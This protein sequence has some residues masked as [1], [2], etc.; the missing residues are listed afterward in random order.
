M[1]IL[2]TSVWIE[3]FKGKEPY[4]KEVLG[5]IESRS[6]IALEPVFGE[7]LQGALSNRERDY[8]MSFW[9]NLSKIEISDLFIKAGNLSY[10]EKLV[11]KGVRLID[12]GIIY[13]TINYKNTLW[14]LDKKILKSLEPKYLYQFNK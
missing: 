4:F 10:E 12:A 5:L 3:F 1:V 8:I 14:T 9:M 2:D 13:S 6:V 7:L 11:S